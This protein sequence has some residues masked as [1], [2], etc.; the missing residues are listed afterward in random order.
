MGL[1]AYDLHLDVIGLT[2]G[3]LLLYEYGIRRL[4]AA[5]CPTDEQPV[6]TR[7]RVAFYCGL[8]VMLVAS[9]WPIH[10]LGEQ[11]L[12][13][14]HMVEHTA[15]SLIVPP[16]LLGGMPWWFTR[17]LLRPVLPVVKF[18]TKPLIALVLFNGWLAFTHVPWV[19]E[20]ML[21]NPLF[22]LLSHALL[23]GTAII[24]WW[25]VM[26]PIP[27]TQSLTPFGKMGYLF[28]QSLVP[29][30]PASFLTL[31]S[32]PLYPIYETFPR[33]W[34][35]SAM[36]DQ[37]LGGLLMKIG[38]GLI[39]WGFIAWVFFSWW[40]DE[41]KYTSPITVVRSDHPPS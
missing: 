24:M 28:L 2:A 16:L 4:A 41:Q 7:K 13:L 8:A 35:L 15:L 9:S 33:M 36:N 10:D 20:L 39:I 29:T 31:G 25:P 17:A 5:Y 12:Y 26:D 21:T 22:H 40:A 32:T 11:R 19:V 3:L 1:P 6:T 38:G 27:D 14:V 34:G 23:F 37:V 18:V 30:I